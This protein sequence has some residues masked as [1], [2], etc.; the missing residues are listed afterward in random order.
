MV[1]HQMRIRM[2]PRGYVGQQR[3]VPHGIHVPLLGRMDPPLLPRCGIGPSH[4]P[5]AIRLLESQFDNVYFGVLRLGIRQRPIHV[6]RP[7]RGRVRQRR[8]LMHARGRVGEVG[9]LLHEV[10]NGLVQDAGLQVM[11]LQFDVPPRPARATRAADGRLG[12]GPRRVGSPE[13]HGAVALRDGQSG[14]GAESI[15]FLLQLFRGRVAGGSLPIHEGVVV[16]MQCR[17]DVIVL[18]L[19]RI[20]VTALVIHGADGQRHAQ[21]A[22]GM[23]LP[24]VLI[25]DGISRLVLGPLVG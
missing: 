19:C 6:L 10:R 25:F 20:D 4:P 11:L 23:Y 15:P 3:K 24:R 7:L 12:R 9:R 8:E 1:H 17:Q 18:G 21:V 16:G 5:L 14:R 13:R 22:I 2:P